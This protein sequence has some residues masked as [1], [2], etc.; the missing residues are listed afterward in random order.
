[1]S[2]AP[3]PRL[4]NSPSAA[5]RRIARLGVAALLYAIAGCSNTSG[6]LRSLAKGAMAKLTITQAPSAAPAT[7]FA[8][9]LGKRHTLAEFKGRVTVVNIWANWCAPCKA[10]IPSL[11]K[12]Q[13]EFAGKPLSVVAI[14]VGKD[15]DE[16]AG[17]KFLDKNPPLTF[18][19]EPTYAIAYA[20]RPMIEG[21]PTTII[22]DKRGVERARLTGGADWS[23]PDARAVMAELIAEK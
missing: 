23:G 19:T 21:M 8:D 6:D 11:A 5:G 18:F 10:E 9:G 13:T 15:D 22:Y 17:H 4:E 16:S 14:S 20:F 2:E 7:A 3:S 12:L 1:M